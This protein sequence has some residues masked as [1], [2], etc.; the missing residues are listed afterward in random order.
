MLKAHSPQV[1]P[2]PLTGTLFPA[3]PPHNMK[4]K[5]IKLKENYYICNY[6]KSNN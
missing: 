6:L 4:Q 2:K 3:P 1:P 5:V